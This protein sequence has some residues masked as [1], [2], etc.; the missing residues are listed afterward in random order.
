MTIVLTYI[1]PTDIPIVVTASYIIHDCL[2]H[3]GNGVPADHLI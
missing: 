1:V 2:C 3:M